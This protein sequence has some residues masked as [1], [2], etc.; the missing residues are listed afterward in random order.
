MRS[1]CR[2][3]SP[4][5]SVSA[6]RARRRSR[7]ATAAA[8]PGT[9]VNSAAGGG[10]R[11]EVRFGHPSGALKVGAAVIQVGGEWKAQKVSMSRSARILMKG[12]VYLPLA[13]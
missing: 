12:E 10:E 11:S 9:L 2:V 1:R 8:I 13:E 4:E 3:F 6:R 5:R 7:F